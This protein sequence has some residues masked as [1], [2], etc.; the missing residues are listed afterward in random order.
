MNPPAVAAT[1]VHDIAKAQR[2]DLPARIEG[3]AVSGEQRFD[4]RYP[5]TGDRAQRHT[6]AHQSRKH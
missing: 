3:E 2:H 5:Y 4:A 1:P 6:N